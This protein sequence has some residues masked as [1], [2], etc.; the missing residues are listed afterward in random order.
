MKIKCPKCGGKKGIITTETEWFPAVC[1][2]CWGKGYVKLVDR[3]EAERL[4]DLPPD[5]RKDEG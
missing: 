2:A 4:I 1:T 5:T 3:A